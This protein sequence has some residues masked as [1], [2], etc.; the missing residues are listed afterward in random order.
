VT[1]LSIFV[2][3]HSC[4]GVC[5]VTDS[6]SMSS[7]GSASDADHAES[8]GRRLSVS[9][10]VAD[11]GQS[12]SVAVGEQQEQSKSTDVTPVSSQLQPTDA[13]S[14]ETVVAHDKSESDQKPGCEHHEAT[15]ADAV[16]NPEA[17]ADAQTVEDVSKPSA[18]MSLSTEQSHE[19]KKF[20]SDSE[21]SLVTVAKEAVGDVESAVKTRG[22]SRVGSRSM[23]SNVDAAGADLEGSGVDSAAESG[24]VKPSVEDKTKTPRVKK[25]SNDEDN[26]D[27]GEKKAKVDARKTTEDKAADDECSTEGEGKMTAKVKEEEAGQ[28]NKVS[29][30]KE[31]EEMQELELGDQKGKG[32]DSAD[33]K[34]QKSLGTRKAGLSMTNDS[35]G[36][37]KRSRVGAEKSDSSETVERNVGRGRR[38]AR[39]GPSDVV[40]SEAENSQEAEQYSVSEGSDSA[41]TKLD[42]KTV[43]QET[44][45]SSSFEVLSAV[46]E[47]SR[48]I[49]DATEADLSLAK[50]Q[51]YKTDVCE[52]SS[53][54]TNSG[55]A[56]VLEPVSRAD[57]VSFLTAAFSDSPAYTS[58]DELGPAG[59]SSSSSAGGTSSLS[60]AAAD[61]DEE[62]TSTKS[63]LEANMEVAAYMGGGSTN[64]GELSS[65][66]DDDD[67]SS[68]NTLSRKPSAKS[69][70]A[71]TKRKSDDGSFQHSGKRRRREKQHRTRSQHA[72]TATK[73]FSY[74]NDGNVSVFV[75]FM[76]CIM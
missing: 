68:V 6:E 43:K 10:S 26:L 70:S 74:R 51:C 28:K 48:K 71:T 52:N 3:L 40:L 56:A 60:P 14:D 5:V 45:E 44:A 76:F 17:T 64:E 16:D 58:A 73:S 61:A 63:E 53:E 32:K 2:E 24:K 4:L 35:S 39:V 41:S 27:K 21:T 20:N 13:A 50:E 18:A 55:A 31:K 7:S 30:L 65:D 36:R 59:G 72:S 49:V 33:H 54:T 29:D 1:V 57:V 34:S 69:S 47:F 12:T 22:K 67:S 19:S 66:E 25:K 9:A 75:D 37:E 11:S 62:H 46:D 42:S 8:A 15:V 23:S 38:K